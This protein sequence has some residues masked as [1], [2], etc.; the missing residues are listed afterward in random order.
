MITKYQ[1]NEFLKF[2]TQEITSDWVIIGGSLLALL[3]A[4]SRSTTD[5]DIC[6][7]DEMTNE[8]R[9][10]LMNLAIKSGLPVESINPSADFFIRQIPN[11][12]NSLI[13]FKTGIK[14]NIYRPS[15]ELYFKLKLSRASDS[16]IQD[17]VSFLEWH[18]EN[19]LEINVGTIQNLL[20]K[21]DSKK[22]QIIFEAL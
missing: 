20:K 1:Y 21:Y 4:K 14:G 2:V 11:W 12:K 5:I 6:P 22:V 18:K 8:N 3:N 17:C 9:L 16:D 13:L 15:L 10:L 7:L 19:F